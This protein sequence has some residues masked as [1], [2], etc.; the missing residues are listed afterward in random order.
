MFQADPTYTLLP[1]A[2]L[3]ENVAAAASPGARLRSYGD[4]N[5]VPLLKA[6]FD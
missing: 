3:F 6:I 2:A 4:K 5:C 1:A